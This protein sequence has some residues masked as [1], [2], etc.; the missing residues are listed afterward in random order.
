MFTILV[1]LDIQTMILMTSIDAILQLSI[2]IFL[3]SLVNQYRGI[4]TYTIGRIF[5]IVSYFISLIKSPFLSL[6]LVLAGVFLLLGTSFA[7]IG[8]AQ[9]TG[10]KIKL[11]HLLI[12]N[13]LFFSVQSYFLIFKDVF[14]FKTITQTVF[15]IVIFSISTYCLLTTSHKSYVGASRFMAI[16]MIGILMSLVARIVLFVKAPPDQLFIPNELNAST[17]I[18]VF[19][20]T[21]LLTVGFIMMVCQ[22][23]YY[24]LKVAANTDVLTH[25]LNRRAM[26]HQLEIAMN[27]FYR[28]DRVFAIILI[29][30]D[31]FKRVNDVYGHDGGD[32]VLVHLAQILQTKMRQI[33]SACRWGGEEF[34]ILL[35]DTTLDQA[36]EIAERL[37]CYV[38]SN[39]SPSNIQITISLGIAVIRQHCNS[40]ESLITAADH[41]LYAAKR[42]GRN[43]VAIAN[44]ITSVEM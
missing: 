30:V 20:F 1:N 5:S 9:F 25:L 6:T 35:P 21:F 10:K 38:E 16:V 26:M 17:L 8:I 32:M 7:C 14:V 11:Y 18:F 40:L 28:S 43:R 22:R 12:I 4:K 27:Q 39:P 3:C 19:V 34:L 15:Q 13:I 23:L 24:D 2:L 44:H 29:D 31:Y 36:E 37:R 42:N 33:D 41:A